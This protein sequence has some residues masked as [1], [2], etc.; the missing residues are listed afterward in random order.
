VWPLS[1]E[2]DYDDWLGN[3]SDGSDRKIAEIILDFFILFK[4]NG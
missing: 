4:E 3:F 1:T 2:L